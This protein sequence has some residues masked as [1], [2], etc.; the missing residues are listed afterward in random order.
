MSAQSPKKLFSQDAKTSNTKNLN[1]F[2]FSKTQQINKAIAFL[3]ILQTTLIGVQAENRIQQGD[4]PIEVLIWMINQCIP[5]L[6]QASK[7]EDKD[8]NK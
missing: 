4:S 1:K 8:K 3:L 2:R 6:K 7:L 5:V